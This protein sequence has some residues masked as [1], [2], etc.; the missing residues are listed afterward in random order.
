MQPVE[1][2]LPRQ[3]VDLALGRHPAHDRQV[4]AR[5]L[6]A[7]DRRLRLGGVGPDH[8]RQQVEPRFV[9][10]NQHPALAPR[11]PA[12][13]RPDLVTPALDGLLVPLDG[14]P[15]RHLGRPVQLLE[16]PADVALVVADAELLLDDLGDAGAGPDLAAEA[17]GLRPVPEE[18][19]DQ[20]LLLR[21]SVG[22]RGPGRGGNE[23]PRDRLVGGGEPPADGWFGDAQS[24]GDVPLRPAL[25]LQAQRP[26]PPP[27]LPVPECR[28]WCPYPILRPE[29]L[30]TLRSDQ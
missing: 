7:D 8:P 10:E 9:L 6:L 21:Q 25:L 24:L 27:L 26:Q 29:K 16:Q 4:V 14:P 12:Q 17:V 13:V 11:P 18:L 28:E 19:R 2:L 23:G 30:T 20:P 22:G 5:L 15:D 1:R 3:G